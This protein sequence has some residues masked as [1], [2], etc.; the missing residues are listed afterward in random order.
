MVLDDVFCT[1]FATLLETSMT[2][3]VSAQGLEFFISQV[4]DQDNI[5]STVKVLVWTL[6]LGY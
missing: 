6:T 1:G 5:H 4:T 3:H 2:T